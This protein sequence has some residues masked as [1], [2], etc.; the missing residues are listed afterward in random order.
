MLNPH[1]L[2]EGFKTVALDSHFESGHGPETA[3]PITC[4]QCVNVVEFAEPVRARR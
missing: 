4:R 1:G 3:G 2:I